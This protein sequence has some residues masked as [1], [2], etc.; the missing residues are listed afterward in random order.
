MPCWLTQGHW[1]PYTH[2]R[3]SEVSKRIVRRGMRV[4]GVATSGFVSCSPLRLHT[5][6]Q[7]RRHSGKITMSHLDSN[8]WPSNYRNTSGEMEQCTYKTGQDTG[9]DSGRMC[10]SKVWTLCYVGYVQCANQGGSYYVY[11]LH[12]KHSV[13]RHF[14]EELVNEAFAAASWQTDYSIL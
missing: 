10:I 1:T 5:A 12:N 4:R 9:L 2:W 6:S 13:P 3:S 8:H 7:P 14:L 11:V